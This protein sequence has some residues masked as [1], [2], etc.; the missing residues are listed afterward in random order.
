MIIIEKIKENMFY[1]IKGIYIYF[2]QH[3]HFFV[4]YFNKFPKT[5][6][7]GIPNLKKSIL[8]TLQSIFICKYS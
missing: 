6:N 1:N 7:I 5:A 3:R 2:L 4:K 8:F